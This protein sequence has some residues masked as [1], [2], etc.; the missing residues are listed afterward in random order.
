MTE[1]AFNEEY[2]PMAPASIRDAASWHLWRHYSNTSDWHTCLALT[3]YGMGYRW[4]TI[5]ACQQAVVL[6]EAAWHAFYLL[7][8]SHMDLGHGETALSR[9][10]KSLKFWPSE[11]AWSKLHY[12]VIRHLADCKRACGD[13]EG[14]YS[15]MTNGLRERPTDLR[16][17]RAY[18]EFI[19]D[20]ETWNRDLELLSETIH[21]LH[22]CRSSRYVCSKASELLLDDLV[23]DGSLQS[24]IIRS[25]RA[26]GKSRVGIEIFVKAI[27]AAETIQKPQYVAA[28]KIDLADLLYENK[29]SITHAV[30]CIRQSLNMDHTELSTGPLDDSHS[31]SLV[32]QMVRYRAIAS[33]TR[34]TSAR[35]LRGIEKGDYHAQ[36]TAYNT[37][38]HLW[39]LGTNVNAYI[40]IWLW[41][42]RHCWYHCF[43]GASKLHDTE[44]FAEFWSRGLRTVIG[45]LA[46]PPRVRGDNMNE[47]AGLPFRRLAYMFQISGRPQESLAALSVRVLLNSTVAALQ[48]VGE[49]IS[50]FDFI[51]DGPCTDKNGP[52]RT[53]RG[54]HRCQLCL[55]TDWCD[56]CMVR[57]EKGEI[58]YTLCSAAH[59]FLHIMPFKKPEEGYVVR[60]N[61]TIKITDWIG[62]L[63]EESGLSEFWGHFKGRIESAAVIG[64]A[65]RSDSGSD[66][67]SDT[68][69][70]SESDLDSE[71]HSDGGSP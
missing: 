1:D 30:R 66:F 31:L 33:L 16:A 10:E 64:T 53:G 58:A 21:A 34:Y 8:L 41:F 54:L 68:Y 59:P 3:Y 71:V 70:D 24:I 46:R 47:G 12:R 35:L 4:S 6:D 36:T 69:V 28:L 43:L 55:D 60:G 49:D 32:Q 5:W 13:D 50:F 57:L 56:D 29:R 67:D 22:G 39:E 17:F 20:K 48:D 65:K 52:W 63:A 7:S 40:P 14:A 23:C 37:L 19:D 11:L 45:M 2:L 9:A 18:I 42:Q 44:R 38:N 26:A 15:T 27:E 51:C 61:C 62:E 25:L